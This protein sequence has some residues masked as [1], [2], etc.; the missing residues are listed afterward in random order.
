MRRGCG[1]RFSG[2]GKG[3]FSR[4]LPPFRTAETGAFSEKTLYKSSPHLR[5]GGGGFPRGRVNYEAPL[6]SPLC[7]LS[8]RNKKVG[9]AAGDI[10]H[11]GATKVYRCEVM[12]DEGFIQNLCKPLRPK[13]KIS[14]SSP[15]G[16]PWCG[17]EVGRDG[18]PVPYGA[19]GCW[20]ETDPSTPC[21]ALRSG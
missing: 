18:S 9:L 19:C 20:G 6:G 1:F 14:A 8:W 15:T 12:L 21:C 11:R 5:R 10:L 3:A 2:L 7:L 17:R 13:S 4:S 16:E